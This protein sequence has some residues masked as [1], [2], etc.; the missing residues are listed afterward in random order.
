[1]A[2]QGVRVMQFL[3]AGRYIG[4][5]AGD[6]VTLYGGGGKPRKSGSLKR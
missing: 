4:N 2:R 3:V 5:V 6:R 1:M